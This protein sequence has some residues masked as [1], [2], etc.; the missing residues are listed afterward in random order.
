M[1]R[2]VRLLFLCLS[3]VS[4]VRT[5]PEDGPAMDLAPFGQTITWAGA[6]SH[7]LAASGSAFPA[8]LTNIGVQWTEER[9]VQEV[10]VEYQA[11]PAQ[12]VGIEY[13]VRAWP[14]APPGLGNRPARGGAAPTAAAASI[15]DPAD[16]IYQGQWLRA[17]TREQ[18]EK[19]VCRYSFDPLRVEESR[20]ASNLPGVTYRRTLKVRLISQVPFPS[21]SAIRV[22]SDSVQKPLSLRIALGQNEKTPS[23][24]SGAV[25]VSNGLLKGVR[26]WSF[27]QGDS[28]QG[29]GEW[30]FTQRGRPKGLI[31]DLVAAEP[32][33][34]GSLDST[35]VSVR[36]KATGA[37]GEFRRSFSFCVDD[38]KQGPIYIPDFYAYVTYASDPPDFRAPAGRGERI[39]QMIPSE[40]EQSYE[41]ASREIPPLD[42][43]ERQYGDKV[44][45]PLAPDSSWQKFAVEYGGNVFISKRGA[46]VKG[47]ER[48]R[49]RWNGDRITWKLGTGAKPYFREDRGAKVSKLDGYLPVVLQEWSN[50][51]LKFNQETFATVLRGS[52]S[53]RDPARSEQTPAV[54]VVRMTARN[55]SPAPRMAHFWVVVE[56]NE[57]V[58][59][60]DGR[61]R[62]ISGPLRAIVESP[63]VLKAA[64]LPGG[65]GRLVAGHVQFSV[66]AGGSE[67]FTVKL[68]FVSD[69]GDDDERDLA[70]LRHEAERERVIAYWKDMVRE[71]VRFSVP[72]PKFNL[73]VRSVVPQI[74]ITATKDPKSGLYMVGAASY[75]YQVFANE[76]CFQALLLDV[77]G[78]H[79]TAEEYFETLLAL[80]GSR[81]YPGLHQGPYEAIFHGARVDEEYDYTASA[82][83]LDHG[84]VLWSL[85]EHYLYSRDR[86]WIERVWPRMQRAID[87]IVAQRA[88]TRLTNANGARVREYGL[89]P[90]S[91][92]ED[93]ADWAHWFAINAYCWA[94]IDRSAEALKDIGHPDAAALRREA[95]AYRADLRNAVERAWR[96][97]PVT[98]LRD[99][100]YSPYVPTDPYQRFRRFGPKRV[101]YYSRYGKTSEFSPTLRLSAT[102]EVLYG[103]IILLNLGVFGPDEP[104]AQWILDDWEDNL[105][106]SSGLGISVHG[107][108]DDAL[109]FSQGG[110]VFQANLQNPVL[111][112]LKRHEIPAAIRSL[113]N[114]FVSCLY[115]DVNIFTEEYRIWQH[116]SG[117]F[118][119]TPDESRFSIRVRDALALEDGDTLWL[120]SGT[121]RRWLESGEGIQVDRLVTYFGPVSYTLKPGGRA[122]VIDATLKL[123]SRRPAGRIYLVVRVP[124]GRIRAVAVN[125][126]PWTKF[127]PA[128]ESIELPPNAAA[129]R[130]EYR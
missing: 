24:W 26:P 5:A 63:G 53:P 68:P 108:T 60:S 85:A 50:E 110:M 7:P 58:R 57:E 78:D 33:L 31:L 6:V 48:A 122:G 20:L 109:W 100:S 106:L 40:P 72:D 9:D 101:G 4:L 118:Y 35:I 102:R 73:L 55:E 82:Y 121:P 99:G 54:L 52:L 44:Y 90:A 128:R 10:R 15:E 88:S 13:W 97:A 76:T 39:R 117:P 11:S 36:A 104:V 43:W 115:P 28:F 130:I 86:A 12:G 74:H 14:Y 19:S 23:G 61:L 47:N 113:Y 81:N 125:G 3:F 123:P 65:D 116:A 91:H 87:W 59:V 98:R 37:G 105:T 103:P 80:Q 107:I 51:G 96:S 29:P 42:P 92:L 62:A 18:C 45:L 70:A 30:S 111:V 2:K 21:I 124:K 93:N 34:T 56:P 79:K 38:L 32:K 119:K 27:S 67:S 127:D 41:R 49:L 126:R 112:Y 83:G 95:D 22:F 66:P 94:G 8:G 25:E 71:A 114:N 17:E 64:S 120:A 84:T 16:D 77:L 129:V 1:S 75:S 46:K 89:L 69:L